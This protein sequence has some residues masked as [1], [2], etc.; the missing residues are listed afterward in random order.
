MGQ[1]NKKVFI[2]YAWQT[3][4]DNRVL[5]LAEKLVADGIDVKFDKWDLRPGQDKYVFMESM[6][7]DPDIDK[8][9]IICDSFYKEKADNR[10]GGVGDETTIVSPSM[11]TAAEQEKFI[12]IL[13][14]RDKQGREF[15][16]IYLASRIYIDLCDSNLEGEEYV[17]LIRHIYEEPEYVKPALGTKPNW[18]DKKVIG[19]ED[20]INSIYMGYVDEWCELVDLDNW[21]SWSSFMF[22]SGQPHIS[23]DMYK[24]MSKIQEWLL[25]RVWPHKNKEIEG[26]FENFRLVLRDL[27]NLFSEHI[28]DDDNMI[29]TEKFYKI[30]RWDDELYSRLHKE[31]EYHVYLVEDLMIELTRAANYICDIVREQFQPDYRIDKGYALI[32]YGPCMDFSFKTRAVK[33]QEQECTLIP[34]EGLEAFKINREN[35]D[36]NFGVGTS[37]EDPKFLNWYRG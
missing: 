16:P 2:S 5:H 7:K 3:D 24:R 18:A 23:K 31:Y 12:P 37:I 9:L 21:N 6:V 8:V 35:R 29:I 26:A 22:G 13:F 10:Q 33:Y 1:K 34:Y 14:E 20:K 25:A 19:V 11:Y 15:L 4:N 27:Y 36:F 28:Q 32:T 17:K 30:D